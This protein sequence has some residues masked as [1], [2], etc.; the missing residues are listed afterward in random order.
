[1]RKQPETINWVPSDWE[2][3]DA[4]TTVLIFTEEDGVICGYW[5]DEHGCWVDC[6]GAEVREVIYWAIAVGPEI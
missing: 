6:T 3:P 2:K 4:D 5:A 1:M